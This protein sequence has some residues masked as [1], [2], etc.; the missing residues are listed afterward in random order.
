MDVLKSARQHR[1][2]C[3]PLRVKMANGRSSSTIAI[4]YRLK[5]TVKQ[6]R[7]VTRG[8]VKPRPS[9]FQELG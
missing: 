8:E 1:H 2:D 6:I 7:V 5:M 9:D 4:I 3:V